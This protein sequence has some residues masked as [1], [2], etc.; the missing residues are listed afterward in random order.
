MTRVVF[1]NL[2]SVSNTRTVPQPRRSPRFSVIAS[3][4]RSVARAGERTWR[5]DR[6]LRRA[7]GER[8]TASRKFPGA[9]P[10]SHARS[11]A[12]S[13]ANPAGS[14]VAEPPSRTADRAARLA[15]R[16]LVH[17]ISPLFHFR[18]RYARREGHAHGPRAHRASPQRP[19][20]PQPRGPLHAGDTRPAT[21]RALCNLHLDSDTGC[22][23]AC[24]P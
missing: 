8:R 19:R 1:A 9:G 5:A 20:R 22:S 23:R 7:L 15:G 4:P 16:S 2:Q 3:R 6:S 24:V 14:S 11:P 17:G 13:P 21:G 12:R 10:V 18:V